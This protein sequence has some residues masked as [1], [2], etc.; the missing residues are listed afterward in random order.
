MR[1]LVL[2]LLL[3][4][5][6]PALAQ[7][8]GYKSPPKALTDLAL[9]APVPAVY[10]A[11]SGQVLVLASRPP[12]LT[13]TD[14]AEPELKLAGLRFNP[15]KRI[16]SRR[17]YLTGLSLQDIATGKVRNVKLPAGMRL[18]DLGWSPDGKRLAFTNDSQLWV[19]DLAS[20]QARQVPGVV[21]HA[22]YPG[23]PYSWMDDQS[24][25]CRVVPQ[26]LGKTPTESAVPSSPVV[27][28]HSGGRAAARTYQ[29]LLRNPYDA[30]VF[31]HAMTSDLVL[32]TLNGVQKKLLRGL[33]SDQTPSPD[34]RYVLVETLHR[35]FS[36]NV[37][38]DRFP[39]R[40]VVV[41]RSGKLVKQVADLPLAES[42]STDF[43][44]C[45]PGPRLVHWRSDQPATLVWAEAQDNGDPRQQASIR[46]KVFSLAAPFS[47]SPTEL[48]SLQLRLS[49]LDWG[50]D[51]L[52]LVTESWWKTR[53]T[54]TWRYGAGEPVLLFDRSSED[55]YSD[56]GRPV[57]KRLPNGES[58]IRQAADG[59]IFLTGLGA[60]PEGNR[61]FL[62][63]FNLETK[64]ASRLWRSEAPYYETLLKL[65]DDGRTL[66]TSRESV[67]E[68]PN[69][70]L[71]DLSA[72]SAKQLTD[73]KHPAPQLTGLSKE[74]IR[75]K[76]ADGVDLSGTLYLPPGYTKE[77]G[78]LPVLMWAYPAEFKSASAAGQVSGSPHRFI[79][80]F[81]G[82]PL[83]F[84]LRGYAVLDNPTF[85]IVGEGKKEPNDTYVEQLLMGAQAAVDEL[86]RRGVGDPDRCAIGGHSYGAFTTANLLAHSDL[87]RAGIAR[88]GAYN[89]T[90]TPFGFQ[91]EERIFWEA[92]DTYVKMS[93]FTVADKIDEPLLLIHG[94]EDNN[95]GTF[96]V[97]SERLFAAL[98]GLG[99][100]ARLVMLPKESHS[101]QARESV[102][103][104]LYEMDRW[105]DQHVKNAGP[106]PKA[107]N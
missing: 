26:G 52:F 79:S 5:L 100:P 37:P 82:G 7:E 50:H 94:A 41:D 9:A 42:L 77:Q 85:P 105:L 81:W 56:P 12:L 73:F 20:A 63:R 103:H 57:F 101:Y 10:A 39:L 104:V 83:F 44:A 13:L 16:Q 14:L 90:L 24:F 36:Y 43:D 97:Q 84:A 65:L 78:P 64:Q 23:A 88:S 53:R 70:V 38:S 69:V 32:A 33:L 72:G 76:R 15:K 91:S 66:L 107:P 6:L 89:R 19:L 4:L 28:E 87:F 22:S 92:P 55:R 59:S 68:P 47:G 106:R 8:N 49:E 102:L 61:P 58:V 21:L 86:K 46:D 35:P 45:R 34:G 98:K 25:V 29:D 31:E 3:L 11:P 30:Q 40:T 93:P 48:A 27:Q 18:R 96:P 1:T 2:L 60:S 99:R 75:Y 54:K 62:D 71:R 51:R 80:P 74:L 95:P 67:S 17:T